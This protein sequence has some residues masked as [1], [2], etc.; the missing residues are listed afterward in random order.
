M[1][2]NFISRDSV[3]NNTILRTLIE[4]VNGDNTVNNDVL[5]QL[6]KLTMLL[7]ILE[8]IFPDQIISLTKC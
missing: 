3:I 8:K 5:S 6:M 2:E 7:R 4:E 1:M